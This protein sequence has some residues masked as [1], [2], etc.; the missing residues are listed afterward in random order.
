METP[1]RGL[2]GK[3]RFFSRLAVEIREALKL[4][5]KAGL[6]E[7]KDGKRDWG[8]VSEHCLVEV[9]RTDVF[10]DMLNLPDD[11]KEDLRVAAAL[12][13]FFKKGEKEIVTKKGLSWDAF[14]AAS[15]E[16]TRQMR[17]EGFS[18]RIVH[19]AN[20][21]GHTSFL[22][23]EDI[24]RKE[25]LSQEDVAYLVQHYV[26][27]YTLG[28]GWTAPAEITADGRH[29]NDLDRRIDATEPNPRYAQLN[30]EGRA[31]FGG[32]TVFEAQR[33]I[34]NA[35]EARLA[36]LTN[37]NSGQSIHPKD[38]PQLIDKEIRKRIQSSKV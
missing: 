20:S 3:T 5:K 14:E 31:K 36:R 34:G 38:L 12:H 22:E 37:E 28:S 2:E 10:A 17:E 4:H 26:D 9:A 30:E 24:L 21:S 18:E 25:S 7:R 8:N 16:S 6:W 32:E 29:I 27:D 11:L 15:E 23:T 1:E 33:R 13:D 19:L 35:V